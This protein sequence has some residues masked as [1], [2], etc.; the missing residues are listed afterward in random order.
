MNNIKALCFRIFSALYLGALFFLP[1]SALPLSLPS[2]KASIPQTFSVLSFAAGLLKGKELFQNFPLTILLLCLLLL[3]ACSVFLIIS[4]FLK[5][6]SRKI[7]LIVIFIIISLYLVT[8]V[9][10][11][12]EFANTIRWFLKLN[13]LVYLCALS[14]LF[15]HVG[16][17]GFVINFYRTRRSRMNDLIRQTQKSRNSKKKLFV[18][19]RTK[20][21]VTILSTIIVILSAF[22]FFILRDYHSMITE[23]VSNTGRAQAEQA[24]AVYDSADGMNDKISKFFDEQ[25]ESNKYS[26]TPYERIDI[27]ITNDSTPYYIENIDSSTKLP[28]YDVFAYTTGNPGKVPEDEKSISSEKALEYVKRYQ[29]GSY[30]KEPVYDKVKKTCLYIHPV[31]FSRKAGQRIKGFSIVRYRTEI[32]MKAY[33]QTQVFVFT[34]SAIFLYIVI[35]ITVLLS[36][37]IAT[38]L[39][40]LRANVHESTNQL[41]SILSGGG[42]VGYES[43]AFNDDIKSRDEI[44]EL[45]VEIKDLVS[46]IRGVI[47][48]LSNSTLKYADREAASKLSVTKELCFLFTD[49]RGF[50]SMCEG[51][52]A[53]DVVSLLN[54][55]LDL[56]SEII[57]K[58]HG[59]IDKFVGDEVMAFFA[60]PRKEYNACK[61]AMEI[62]AAMR[63][64]QKASLKDGSDYVSMGI[65][66]NS[67]K[68]TFGSVGSKNRMDF[69]SIGDAVNLAARLEGVNKA[70]GSKA[71]ISEAVFE[72]LN[73]AFICRELDYITVKGKTEPVRI[74]EILQKKEDAS[75][76]IYDIRDKFESGLNAYRRQNWDKAEVSF[77]ECV[78]LYNDMP[79]IIFLDRIRH[80]R[81]SPPEKNWDGVFNIKIK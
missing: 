74:Y 34:L 80:F 4:L 69:T 1:I 2:D 51:R 39:I 24:A 53:K 59:D 25:R 27:I 23:S 7:C 13:P 3:P 10:C 72:K 15:C 68:V 49:I 77:K 30:R 42:K 75:L 33:F 40:Y 36:D 57:I 61:A 64:A 73:G 37:F 54:H 8:S 35:I 67:G 50:T 58:N 43:L 48:Y 55:Y 19:I 32:L 76:K 5:K 62:R 65:G 21:L 9:A 56:E 16:I 17:T 60:G 20:V 28:D 11:M 66:I 79:S 47:P 26:N 31:T 81:K 38:P 52:P 12:I 44:G 78:S 46:L 14:A 6:I 29:N 45:S 63:E 18:S 70:Y 71:I 41:S 22:T